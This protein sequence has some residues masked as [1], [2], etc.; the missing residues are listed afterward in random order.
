MRI[1]YSQ[2][3]LETVQLSMRNHMY[4]MSIFKHDDDVSQENK[5]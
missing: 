4:V 3:S 5:E 2:T 1:N